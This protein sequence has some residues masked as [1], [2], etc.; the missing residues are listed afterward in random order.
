MGISRQKRAGWRDW[1]EKMSGKAWSEKPIVDPPLLHWYRP[2]IC[3]KQLN[4]CLELR[5]CSRQML[6]AWWLPC[7]QAPTRYFLLLHIFFCEWWKYASV[8]I[9]LPLRTRNLSLCWSRFLRRTQ[10]NRIKTVIIGRRTLI[11][12]LFESPAMLFKLI[13]S[14]ARSTQITLLTFNLTLENTYHF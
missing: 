12:A 10:T 14:P 1:P 11:Q 8:T 4:V 13:H 9:L 3:S 5:K 2:R 7:S 6:P